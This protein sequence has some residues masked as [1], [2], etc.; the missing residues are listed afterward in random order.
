LSRARRPILFKL[1][2][3][4]PWVKKIVNCSNK[5]PGLHQSGVD[6]QKKYQNEAGSFKNFLLKNQ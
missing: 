3:N 4:Y 2:T 6:N 1:G 5:G